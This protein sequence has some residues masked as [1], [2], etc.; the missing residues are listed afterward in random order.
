MSSNV[1]SRLQASLL[2]NSSWLPTVHGFSVDL[3]KECEGGM[4]RS[5]RPSYPH[6]QYT[7]DLALGLRLHKFDRDTRICCG[8]LHVSAW[9]C[10]WSSLSGLVRDVTTTSTEIVYCMGDIGPELLHTYHW[11]QESTVTLHR[12]CEKHLFSETSNNFTGS[13]QML[14]ARVIHPPVLLRRRQRPYI[15]R[16]ER[17]GS[18]LRVLRA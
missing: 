13:I 11:L 10:K 15:V 2:T 14:P 3:G 9:R 6:F 18:L 5:L 1:A 16:A 8:Y 7:P 17:D 4:F 12:F